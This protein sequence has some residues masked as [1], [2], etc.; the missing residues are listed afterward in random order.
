MIILSAADVRE[1]LPVAVCIDLMRDAMKALSAGETHQMLRQ[2]FPAPGG[3]YG[4]MGGVMPGTYGSKLISVIHAAAD[5]VAR[6]SH[7]GVV[8]LFNPATGEPSAVLEAGSVTA[9]RTAAASAMAT[10]VLARRDATS[11]AVLGAG[12]QAHM[13]AVAMAA[14]R[15]L[16]SI[17]LWARDTAKAAALAARL[18]A[19]LGVG[20]AVAA[21][22]AECVAN[23][24]I[25][26][27][28]T[29]AP[30][31]ILRAPDIAVGTHLNVV[32]SSRAGPSEIDTALVAR[33]RFF[34]DSRES[35]LSQGAEFIYAREEGLVTD[36]HFLAEI[37]E[38]LLGRHAGRG[39]D[40]DITIYKSLGHIVQDLAA[41]RHVVAAG[42]ASGK[43]VTAIL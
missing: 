15:P 17:R 16:S 5:G 29:A 3:A 42:A 33:A 37:G 34:G 9:I 6:P 38:V 7:Q 21:T 40:E 25:V 39:S 1:M 43:G 22:P 31:P 12:E 2:I 23:V 30:E 4:I 19:E 20:C 32:G 26:C 28:T 8:M 36:D 13:H 41:A 35:V 27:T 14:V 11:L 18:E 10:D 24:D